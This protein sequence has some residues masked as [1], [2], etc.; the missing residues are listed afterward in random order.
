MTT[1]FDKDYE[2]FKIEDYHWKAMFEESKIKLATSYKQDV[3]YL[4]DVIREL[5]S[6]I[7]RLEEIDRT[8]PARAYNF[9]RELEVL[10]H[11]HRIGDYPVPCASGEI[12]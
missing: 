3:L 5:Q 4:V 1:G 11:K 8:E 12:Q 10:L 6:K 7:D 9:V 2:R